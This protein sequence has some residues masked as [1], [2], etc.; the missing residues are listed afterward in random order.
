MQVSKRR[1]Q[2]GDQH[3]IWLL[4]LEVMK[5]FHCLQVSLVKECWTASQNQGTLVLSAFDHNCLFSKMELKV[6]QIQENLNSHIQF[7]SVRRLP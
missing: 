2:K 5:L 1:I 6:L 4:Q 3:M 7:S